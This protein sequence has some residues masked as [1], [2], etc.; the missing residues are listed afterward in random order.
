[1]GDTTRLVAARLQ[2]ALEKTGVSR[3]ALAAA[4][5]VTP[6]AVSHWVTGRRP[7][8]PRVLGRI[9]E[10]LKIDRGWLMGRTGS[11]LGCGSSAPAEYRKAAQERI[12]DE[13]VD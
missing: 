5:G 8:P 6:G 10:F 12:S 11:R 4:L 3:A 1:M 13:P 9:A 7:C 2:Q